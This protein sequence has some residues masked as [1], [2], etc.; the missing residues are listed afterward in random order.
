MSP[1]SSRQNPIYKRV[2]KLAQ[3]SRERRKTGKTV[4]DGVHLV[5]AYRQAVGV[6]ELVAVRADALAHPEIETLLVRLRPLEPVVLSVGLFNELVP[7]TTP[8]GVLAVVDTPEPEPPAQAVEFCLLLEDIQDPGNL[9]SILRSAA[10]AACR[11][12][13]TSKHSVFAWSPRVLRAAMGAHFLLHIH[14]QQ[15]LQAV[16]RIFEGEVIATVAARGDSIYELD[17]TGRLALA[18]GNEGAGLSEGLLRCARARATIPMPGGMESINVAAAAAICLFERV[19]QS[20][21]HAADRR[22]T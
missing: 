3:S 10:A 21:S 4:L 6:P 5:A 19:R 22:R 15:D 20:A 7:S 9:G 11:H 16:A 2:L 12:V 13:Y 8:V 17:L 14:E 1:I 18:I